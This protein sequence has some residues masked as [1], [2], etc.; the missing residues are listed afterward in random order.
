MEKIFESLYKN[1][2][3]SCYNDILEIVE[4]ILGEGENLENTIQR[5]SK[6]VGNE[7][8]EKINDFLQK[9]YKRHKN[10]LPQYNS[11][12]SQNSTALDYLKKKVNDIAD[13]KRYV[14]KVGGSPTK[15]RLLRAETTDR[16]DRDIKG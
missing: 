8:H 3:E 9:V 5:V 15:A 4:A 7:K 10:E 6:M 13:S 1:I 16:S 11:K 12:Y 2:S 14:K